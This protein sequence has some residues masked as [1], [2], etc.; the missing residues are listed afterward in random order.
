VQHQQ[1]EDP[2]ET[3][4]RKSERAGVANLKCH[5]RISTVTS[6]VFDVGGGEV[7]A[8]H[9]RHVA[10]FG[11]RESEAAR[12]AT[13]I[14]NAFLL[15]GAD[16]VRNGRPGACSSGPS[17][18]HN[19]RRLQQRTWMM[20]SRRCS[21]IC[22]SEQTLPP[23]NML[24]NDGGRRRAK[25]NNDHPRQVPLISGTSDERVSREHLWRGIAPRSVGWRAVRVTGAAM[26]TNVLVLGDGTGGVV[27]ANLLAREARRRDVP[28]QV[29]LIGDSP[30]HTYQ[31]GMLFLPFRLPGYRTLADIQRPNSGFVGPG[32]EYRCE[33][34][35]AIDAAARTVST[36][37]GNANTT[38]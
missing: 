25:I 12:A 11:Y 23:A 33:R 31:P 18:A 37:E 1:G 3:L 34:I 10:S 6:C 32:I 27:A 19:H 36:E 16:E 21:R 15:G 8:V 14:E 35:T 20:V 30:M 28:L 9:F 5:S 13:N 17:A 7:D 22:A 26:N 38:G 24:V 2:V 4:V 29:V